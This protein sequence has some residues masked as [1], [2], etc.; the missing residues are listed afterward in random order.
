VSG[1]EGS[2]GV[3]RNLVMLLIREPRFPG[4]PS[5]VR[6]GASEETV[7]FL[8]KLGSSTLFTLPVEDKMFL[9]FYDCI[10]AVKSIP[11]KIGIVWLGHSDIHSERV[12]FHHNFC[13][14]AHHAHPMKRWLTV[15]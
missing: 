9:A 5:L 2:K 10:Y 6:E 12:T 11:I 15:K 4:R 13:N 3:S 7:G 8:D 1:S 14:V